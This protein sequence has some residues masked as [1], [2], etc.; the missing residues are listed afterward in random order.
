M[1]FTLTHL[2]ATSTIHMHTWCMY[3]RIDSA[4]HPMC[5]LCG[6]LL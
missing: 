1:K 2:P 3:V 6:Q 4:K 5:K